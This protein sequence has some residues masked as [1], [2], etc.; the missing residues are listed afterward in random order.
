[1]E[2]KEE[3]EEEGGRKGEKEKPKSKPVQT[4]KPVKNCK[5]DTPSMYS[6]VSVTK[7]TPGKSSSMEVQE[8]SDED[9]R[10]ERGDKETGNMGGRVVE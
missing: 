1:M 10:D 7:V 8:K 9:Q 4:P 3:E 5:Q 2:G 6:Y